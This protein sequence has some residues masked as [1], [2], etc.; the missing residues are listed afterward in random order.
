MLIKTTR[1]DKR[2]EYMKIKLIKPLRSLVRINE[3]EATISP[4]LFAVS[5]QYRFISKLGST[6][7][8]VLC[9]GKE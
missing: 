9:F 6:F 5:I 7:E 4:R 3:G 1:I 2:E 8:A